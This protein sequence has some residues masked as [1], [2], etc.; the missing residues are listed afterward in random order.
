[1][2]FDQSKAL[3]CARCGGSDH[4]VGHCRWP[5]D[6]ARAPVAKGHRRLSLTLPMIESRCVEEGDCLLWTGPVT[7]G[8]PYAWSDGR[9][10][11]IRRLVY[12]LHTGEPVP[13]GRI[14]TMRCGNPSCLRLSHITT[15]TRKQMGAKVAEL[16][17]LKTPD[18]RAARIAAVRGGKVARLT[19]AQADEIRQSTDSVDELAARYGVHRSH[20]YRIIRGLAWAPAAIQGASVFGWR[21]A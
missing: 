1:M 10:T 12:Q 3:G 19:M 17:L 20:V 8:S 11:S 7:N 21:P 2:S 15:M 5:A 9:C 4:T 14:V 18:I 16:G 6:V 13:K